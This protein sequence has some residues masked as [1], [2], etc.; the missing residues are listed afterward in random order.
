ML[1]PRMENL[2]H[3]VFG[4]D[5]YSRKGLTVPLPSAALAFADGDGMP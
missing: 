3:W 4:D 1:F 5:V 2:Y